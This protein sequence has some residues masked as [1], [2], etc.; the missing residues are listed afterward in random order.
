[1]QIKAVCKNYPT[2]IKQLK[3][4]GLQE[5]ISPNMNGSI[6]LL[7]TINFKRRSKNFRA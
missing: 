3:E 7:Q 6:G 4:K 5:K 2:I 1:M